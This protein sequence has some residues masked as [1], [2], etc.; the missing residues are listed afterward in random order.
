MKSQL[1]TPGTQKIVSYSYRYSTL[2]E[3]CSEG[4]QKLNVGVFWLILN[5]KEKTLVPITKTFHQSKSCYVCD[6]M[7]GTFTNPQALAKAYDEATGNMLPTFE[8]LKYLDE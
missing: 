5:D 2:Y 3:N 4:M 7:P 8:S 6:T 1:V